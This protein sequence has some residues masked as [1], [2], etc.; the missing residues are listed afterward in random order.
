[1]PIEPSTWSRVRA[2][3]PA[4]VAVACAALAGCGPPG[5]VVTGVVTLDKRPV[6]DAL[7]EF[8]PVSGRGSVSVV[9]TD[10]A[11][12]YRV[13]A[14]PT[15]MSVVIRATE[16][17]G[18]KTSANGPPMMEFRNLL[19]ERYNLHATT[20]LKAVPVR[21]KTVTIDFNMTSSGE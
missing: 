1:M 7:V 18:M 6:A 13:N 19:P 10:A 11:G 8:Y 16:K 12:R 17:L 3:L 15:E 5:T 21:H 14:A 20:P 4:M 2:F 9:T